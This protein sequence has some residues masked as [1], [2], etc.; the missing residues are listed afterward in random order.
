M[1]NWR[2][3][4]VGGVLAIVIAVEPI[5]STGVIDWRRVGVA[6]LIALVSYLAKDSGVSGTAK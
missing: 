5:I 4:L 6:A 1:K 2:T 3:T